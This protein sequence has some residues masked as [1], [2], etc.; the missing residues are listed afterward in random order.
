MYLLVCFK[1]VKLAISFIKNRGH[2]IEG[3]VGKVLVDK[4]CSNDYDLFCGDNLVSWKRKKHHIASKSTLKL[5]LRLQ[6]CDF[7]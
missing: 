4:R 1:S 7:G 6:T 5:K 3:L 2:L